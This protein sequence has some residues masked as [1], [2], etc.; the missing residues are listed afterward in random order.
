MRVFPPPVEANDAGLRVTEDASYPW[1]WPEIKKAVGVP[2]ASV[3]SHPA[4]MPDSQPTSH[5]EFTRLPSRNA[6]S[7]ASLTHS[8][9]RR[10]I[11]DMR[12]RRNLGK[13]QS[14]L[15]QPLRLA[16]LNYFGVGVSFVV[17]STG[18]PASATSYGSRAAAWSPAYR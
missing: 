6:V 13:H 1:A 4:I 11:K 14:D 10:A 12:A 8:P 9:G 17:Y 15:Q 18:S 16:L 7:R 3:C 2:K 5:A